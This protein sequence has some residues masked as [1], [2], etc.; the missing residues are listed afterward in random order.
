[1]SRD[2]LTD[3]E[4]I[5]QA[6]DGVAEALQQTQTPDL[7]AQPMVR[8]FGVNLLAA[9]ERAEIVACSACGALLANGREPGY[10]PVDHQA[11][12]DAGRPGL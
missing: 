11:D 10:D 1:M 4:L 9:M 3:A 12:L 7:L 5:A 6:I 2:P 8:F